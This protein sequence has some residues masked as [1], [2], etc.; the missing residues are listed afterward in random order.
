MGRL[1]AEPAR[2]V[3]SLDEFFALAYA[4]ETDAAALQV[5]AQWSGGFAFRGGGFHGFHHGFHHGFFRRRAFI[6]FGFWPY[7][8]DYYP[9]YYDDYY[10]YDEGCYLVRRR[11]HTRYGWR[12]RNVEVC[13]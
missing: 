9:Y 8:A 5:A 7:Y 1:K 11:V 6:G 3:R 10:P 13:G 2:P 12:I 4:V